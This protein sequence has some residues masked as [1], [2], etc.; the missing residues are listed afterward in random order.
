MLLDTLINLH[1]YRGFLA[2]NSR[3]TLSVSILLSLYTCRRASPES[4]S[5]R[6]VDRKYVLTLH[7]QLKDRSEVVVDTGIL[8]II[9][10]IKFPKKSFKPVL[11]WLTVGYAPLWLIGIGLKL[12]EL[13]GTP[14]PSPRIPRNIPPGRKS[15]DFINWAR[16]GGS[17]VNKIYNRSDRIIIRRSAKLR[18]RAAQECS[19][20]A[21]GCPEVASECPKVA[22]ELVPDIFEFFDSFFQFEPAYV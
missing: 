22:S 12:G 9:V 5:A 6:I 19:K 17:P 20:V 4:F 18:I 10:R 2:Q 15:A 21:F 13:D 1:R 7:I 16:L 14:P 8:K 11:N 3:T